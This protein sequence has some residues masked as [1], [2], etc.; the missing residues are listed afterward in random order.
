MELLLDIAHYLTGKKI[1]SYSVAP[2]IS[3]RLGSILQ[4]ARDWHETSTLEALGGSL[5]FQREPGL[6][7]ISTT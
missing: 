4:R 6:S 2:L 3:I 1:S 7:V 5:D